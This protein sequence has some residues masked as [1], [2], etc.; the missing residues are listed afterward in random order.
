MPD[1]ER[2]LVV[3]D[4]PSTRAILVKLLVAEGYPVGAADTA[5]QARALLAAETFSLVLLDLNL[6]DDDGLTLARELSRHH[7]TGIIMVSGRADDMDRIIGLEVGADDYVTKPFVPR[8]LMARVRTVLRRLSPPTE[9]TGVLK[10]EGW[11]L[12]IPGRSLHRPDGRQVHLTRAEFDLLARLA[13]QPGRVHTRHQLLTA[14]SSRDW[15]PV[16]RTIDVLVRRLRRKI[17][18]DPKSPRLILTLS[19]HGYKFTPSD[20]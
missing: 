10:F 18:V 4:E 19:G 1:R 7:R 12:D 2:I 14:V 15:A 6:P 8:E 11:T 9:L 17:E 3:E 20:A 13:S 16:D 5:A